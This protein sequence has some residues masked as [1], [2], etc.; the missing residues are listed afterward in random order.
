MR[1]T[2]RLI[3]KDK[4]PTGQVQDPVHRRASAVLYPL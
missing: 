1:A 3:A 4:P 2:K